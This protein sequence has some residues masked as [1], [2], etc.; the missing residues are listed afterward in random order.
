MDHACFGPECMQSL[1][2]FIHVS[3]PPQADQNKALQTKDDSLREASQLISFSRSSPRSP[4]TP[5]QTGS[6]YM[7][8]W[9]AQNSM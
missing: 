3:S 7:H 4:P 6:Y 1:T 8:P 9:L 5:S 2:G